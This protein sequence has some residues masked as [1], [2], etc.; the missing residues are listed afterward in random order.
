M[1]PLLHWSTSIRISWLLCNNSSPSLFF[2]ICFPG[3][4]TTPT[5]TSSMSITAATIAVALATTTLPSTRSRRHSHIRRR[6]VCS[7]FSST[8]GTSLPASLYFFS[9]HSDTD[10]WACSRSPSSASI[11]R[12]CTSSGTFG[13]VTEQH[14]KLWIGCWQAHSEE[15]FVSRLS[16]RAEVGSGRRN[17]VVLKFPVRHTGCTRDGE[18]EERLY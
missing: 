2:S 14:C 17:G 6:N 4:V 18:D 13:G 16:A 10:Y 9:L 7:L 8:C 11:S 5:S 3:N 15:V 1:P 12:A